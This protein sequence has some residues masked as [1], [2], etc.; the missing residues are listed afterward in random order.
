M[1]FTNDIQ[2]LF[3]QG[4]IITKLLIINTIAFIL[5]W[6]VE[7]VGSISHTNV[8]Y[9]VLQNIAAPTLAK[10][11]LR[12]IWTIATFSFF[13]TAFLSYFC[14]MI[15]LNWAGRIFLNFLNEKKF[16]ATYILGI[17]SGLAL[18]IIGSSLSITQGILL[19]PAAAVLAVIV[20][21]AT[22][23][24]NY[25]I[26]LLFFGEV[27]LKVFAIIIA[28]FECLPLI[29]IFG[30]YNPQTLA[31]TFYKLGGVLYGFSWAYLLRK[32]IDI[33]MWLL[34]F[35][36]NVENTRIEKKGPKMYKHTHRD[37]EYVSYEEVSY[38]EEEIDTILGK[39]S[40]SGYDSL[41]KEEKEK[42]FKQNKK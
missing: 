8:Y 32:N 30:Q 1:T 19:G 15:F 11:F 40:K 10:S 13:D 25:R 17:F 31:S 26:Y 28:V 39:I 2:R 14:N 7:I 9:T 42:L 34:K 3:K 27:P 16:L 35:I 6:M 12:K 4:D 21:A 41:T 37:E 18:S 5:L 23:A 29:S 24:P 36:T 22:Y 38:D 33:S 20:A